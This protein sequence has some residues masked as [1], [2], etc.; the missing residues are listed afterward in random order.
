MRIT[1]DNTLEDIQG[2]LLCLEWDVKKEKPEFPVAPRFK[3]LIAR[4]EEKLSRNKNKIRKNWF[5]T[6]REQALNA[7]RAFRE[8]R[9]DDSRVSLKR[10]WEYLEQGNKAHKRKARF[11]ASEDGLV[12]ASEKPR[13]SPK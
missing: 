8:H 3:E 7:Q 13:E 4:I 5:E 12:I 9:V 1:D 10:C 6:A 11:L 2:L